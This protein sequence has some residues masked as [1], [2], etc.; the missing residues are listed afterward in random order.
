M[1]MTAIINK[2]SSF[3]K[4]IINLSS[5]FDNYGKANNQNS[6]SIKRS[7]IDYSILGLYLISICIVTLFHEPW[8]D[9]AQSW[10]IAKYSSYKDMI[11]SLGHGEG[12]PA[13]WWIYLSIFAKTGF[14]FEFGLKI[15]SVLLNLI[16]TWILIFKVKI[17]RI[18]RYTI[19]FTY[20]FFYQY[21][22]ISRCYSIL[23]IAIILLAVIWNDRAI[24]PQKTVFSL[25][26]L[27]LSSAYG[28]ALSF[29]LAA[30]WTFELF[31][32]IFFSK[33]LQ[34]KYPDDTH[35]FINQ[36][37]SLLV[38]LVSA[39]IIVI[40]I[41]PTND[42]YALRSEK[43]NSYFFRFFYMIILEPID[44]LFF[45]AEYTDTE[46]YKFIPDL[47][48][49][50]IGCIIAFIFYIII[51]IWP[52]ARGMRRYLVIP[53]I[54]FSAIASLSFF[55][56]HHMGITT[57]LFLFW[58]IIC[59]THNQNNKT[60]CSTI[61][62]FTF[63]IKLRTW[64]DSDEAK[65]LRDM[66]YII[67][68]LIIIV[69]IKWSI[70]SSILDYKYN[71]SAERYIYKE[72]V[73]ANLADAKILPD[74]LALCT[75]YL[76]NNDNIYKIHINGQDYPYAINNLTDIETDSYF[77]YW[78]FEVGWPDIYIGTVNSRVFNKLQEINPYLNDPPEY[79]PLCTT[80]A[81]SIFK[82]EYS[83]VTGWTDVTAYIR[84]D[85]K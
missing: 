61:K 20:F 46:L 53:H 3:N 42:P 66:Y 74:D 19:P 56:S 21:G 47:Y 55:W 14:P 10:A 50:I 59:Y 31:T 70:E 75:S 1:T 6:K 52:K 49:T 30:I 22:V 44:S 33:H 5:Q 26:L 23:I 9:E 12:H 34:K 68:A 64:M 58:F 16:F 80:E 18:M 60:N 79:V 73:N 24:K 78:A 43:Y 17:P 57:A 13:L 40:L 32:P 81:G 15:A 69:S 28:I 76:D 4:K 25:I 71:Y 38:L 65:I 54:I 36:L 27:C 39:I 63:S 83:G 11:F 37:L 29:S 51:F 45:M 82:G 62:H 35:S 72:I 85:F 67:P 84:K 7:Y 2:F 8:G 48:S 41:Y 77:R